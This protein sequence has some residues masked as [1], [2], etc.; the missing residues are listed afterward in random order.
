VENTQSAVSCIKGGSERSRTNKKNRLQY[1]AAGKTAPQ[2]TGYGTI[3]NSEIRI[4]IL[5]VKFTIIT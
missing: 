5:V 4:M 2:K 1:L 3:K